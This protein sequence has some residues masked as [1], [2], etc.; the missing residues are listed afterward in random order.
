M[1][2]LNSQS[3]IEDNQKVNHKKAVRPGLTIS[4]A[5]GNR[6]ENCVANARILPGKPVR[7]HRPAEAGRGSET[8]KPPE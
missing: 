7:L 4:E 2:V 3:K 6:W 1:S 8:T 5:T